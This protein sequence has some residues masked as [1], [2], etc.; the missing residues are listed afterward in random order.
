[1]QPYFFPYLGYYSLI[2]H[3]DAWI[4]FDSVQYIRH[5]WIERNRVLKPAEGWQYI[6]V[7]LEKHGRDILIR[8]VKIR[9]EDWRDRITRQLAHY[10]KSPYFEP[11]MALVKQCFDIDTNDIT[12]LNAHILEHTCRYL[13][14]SFN[15]QV[16]SRMNLRIGEVNDAG[17]WALQISK[18]FGA[19]GYVNPPGG[20]GLFDSEKFKAAAIDLKFLNI[21][22]NDYSQRRK[23]FEPGLSIIDVMMFNSKEDINIMLDDFQITTG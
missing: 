18:A 20:A 4:I 6:S 16:F 1:M 15:Y 13:G 8:D 22:L 11:V 9:E 23:T 19:S 10:K 2:K 12:S 3:T 17:D 14:I 7:P 21:N 5:G